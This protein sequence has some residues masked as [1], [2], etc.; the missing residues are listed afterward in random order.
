MTVDVAG[1]AF[2]DAV[3]NNNTAATQ[4]I[5]AFDTAPPTIAITDDTP[6]TATGDVTYTFTLS[7]ASTTFAAGDITVVGGTA[8]TFTAVSG[9]QYTLVVTPPGNSTGNMT[10]DVAGSV[11][12]DAAGN[13]N[14]AATQN[15]QAISTVVS[16]V[17]STGFGAAATTT[18]LTATFASAATGTFRYYTDIGGT[19]PYKPAAP[20]G[21]FSGTTATISDAAA[22]YSVVYAIVKD[23]GGLITGTQLVVLNVAAAASVNRS[24]STENEVIFGYEGASTL[25]GGS[26]DDLIHGG[27]GV[28]NIHG[29]PG[30]DIITGGAG[31]N[32]FHFTAADIDSTLG[33]VTDIVM[34]FDFIATNTIQS[35]AGTVGT[36]VNYHEDAT[37]FADLTGL[38]AAADLRLDGAFIYFVGQVGP[39]SYLVTDTDGIGYTEVIKLVGVTL[40]EIAPGDIIA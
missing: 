22:T 4:S 29:G 25:T 32:V 20:A 13:N 31:A 24:S 3:G 30:V 5:Q 27:S 39:D 15:V 28:D 1:G 12:T 14:T 21:N 9:T 38:L 34:D 37:A 10:V 17:Y 2:T 16:P 40:A 23:S 19:T 35:A 18:V 36:G 33:A 8:G 7:E 6:A 26:G 11:F